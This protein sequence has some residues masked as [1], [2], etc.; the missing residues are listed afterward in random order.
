MS[1]LSWN[2]RGLGNAATI[3]ELRDMAKNY[4]PTVVCVLETQVHKARVEGLKSTLGYANAFAVN[5]SG[6]SGGLGLFW[7]NEIKLEILPYSHYHIDAIVTEASGNKWQLTRVYGE[8]QTSERFKTWNM[9]KFIKSSSALPWLCI[10]D[11]NEVL[12]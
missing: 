3:E 2:C 7:N 8:A 9:L 12:H 4:T 6:R 1:L 10:G 5:C 11:F